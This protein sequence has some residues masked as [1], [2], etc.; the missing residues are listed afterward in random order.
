MPSSWLLPRKRADTLAARRRRERTKVAQKLSNQFT[1][2]V[3]LSLLERSAITPATEQAYAKLV[4]DF[5]RFAQESL[6]TW[7]SAAELDC[8]LVE[9]LNALFLVGAASDVG[10]RLL[11]AL[12]H[13]V[14]ELYK[15]TR[16]LLP[17]A[18]R[19]TVAWK[20][21]SPGQM[22]L[23]LPRSA[24]LAISAVLVFWGLPRMAFGVALS[25]VAYLRPSELLQLRGVHIIGPSPAAGP[26][27]AFWGLLL[28]DAS[29]GLGHFAMP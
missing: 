13:L 2:L 9:Y 6:L 4:S 5:A 7:T 3:G 23:P 10:P 28:H 15:Q 12:S 8:I 14:P 29:C 1:Q 26:E 25:H 18:T 11:A 16:T 20:R 21:R 22:R 27:Y 19:C 24:A 17:R